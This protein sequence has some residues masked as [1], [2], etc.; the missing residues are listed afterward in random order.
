MLPQTNATVSRVAGSS[1]GEAFDGPAGPGPEK[2][3]G[4]AD[5]YLRERRDR[6]TGPGGQART[7][8]RLLILANDDPAIVWAS[9]DT[10]EFTYRGEA[11]SAVVRLVD[12]HDV[13]DS[14]IPPEFQTTRL[15][16]ET[17]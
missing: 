2:W 17:A 9:G 8:D 6:T 4:A 11:Q 7:L 3:A 13:D 15:T 14:D 1:A 12:R 10:V 5:A 16:L